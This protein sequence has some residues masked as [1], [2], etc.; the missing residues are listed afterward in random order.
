MLLS[1]LLA[2][3][4]GWPLAVAALLLFSAKTVV[5][6]LF[7]G[8]VVRY[9]GR[10]ELLRGYLCSQLLHIAYLLVIGTL[11]NFVR[12]YKWKGRTVR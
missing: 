3:W 6:F 11:A 8:E 2:P 4:L 1:C 12:R 9:F 5:D 10:S 7:L